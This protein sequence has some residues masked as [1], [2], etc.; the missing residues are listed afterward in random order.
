MLGWHKL[1]ETYRACLRQQQVDTTVPERLPDL[2][3]E[4]NAFENIIVQDGNIPVGFWPEGSF[5]RPC[6]T[7]AALFISQCRSTSPFGRTATVD[8]L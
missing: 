7:F 4:T 2:I 6:F 1:W 5:L 3:A 8:G